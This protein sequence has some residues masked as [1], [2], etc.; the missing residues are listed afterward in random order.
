MNA[1]SGKSIPHLLSNHSLSNTT[2]EQPANAVHPSKSDFNLGRSIHQFHTIQLTSQFQRSRVEIATAILHPSHF[3]HFQG[4]QVGHIEYGI[5][6]KRFAA[7]SQ[8]RQ[9]FTVSQ[10]ETAL[11]LL[12][13]RFTTCKTV[14]S[15]DH[16]LQCIQSNQLH[17]SHTLH[18]V[19]TNLYHSQL[20]PVREAKRLQGAVIAAAAIHDQMSDGWRKARQF[21]IV[22]N[23]RLGIVSED[24]RM[25]REWTCVYFS[26]QSIWVTLQCELGG[27]LECTLV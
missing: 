11:R 9:L 6:G 16:L 26:L 21:A 19:G 24:W 12:I 5:V 15:D 1:N 3:N 17:H 10:G 23:S 25:I 13:L 7:H 4:R 20:C 2:W 14:H 8:L 18:T 27:T 22:S